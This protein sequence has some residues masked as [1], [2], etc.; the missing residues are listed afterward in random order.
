M[1]GREQLAFIPEPVGDLSAKSL[2]ALAALVV[3]KADIAAINPDDGFSTSLVA[4][5][6]WR[7]SR[8][9]VPHACKLSDSKTVNYRLFETFKAALPN[10][11]R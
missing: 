6:R 5:I 9:D 2:E 7:P 10:A 11:G 3:A 8:S 1:I 4:K